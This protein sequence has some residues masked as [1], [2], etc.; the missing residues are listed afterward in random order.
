M[1][2]VVKAKNQNYCS[3]TYQ[4]NSKFSIQ[5][6]NR[7]KSFILPETGGSGTRRISAAG[8]ILLALGAFLMIRKLL[9]IRG[10]GEGGGSL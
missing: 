10:A 6:V 8:W 3:F 7:K 2:G 5:V 1:S 9:M 4:R